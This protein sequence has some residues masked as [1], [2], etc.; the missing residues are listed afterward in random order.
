MHS[1]LQATK[2]AVEDEGGLTIYVLGGANTD[3]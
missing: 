1:Q 3:C 2:V